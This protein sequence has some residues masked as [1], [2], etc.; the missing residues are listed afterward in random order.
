MLKLPA[1][2]LR[3]RVTI[4]ELA[5]E[6]DSDGAQVDSWI[7]FGDGRALPAEISPL[8]ARELIAAQAVHSKV[9]TRIRLRYRTGITAAMR[10]RHRDMVYEIEGVI[11]DPDSGRRFITLMTTSLM[12][13][14]APSAPA[15]PLDAS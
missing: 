8:S 13:P 2:R 9:T 6:L 14:L 7:T 4:E 5:S 11:P 3:H 10:V 15:Q 1:G 12:S